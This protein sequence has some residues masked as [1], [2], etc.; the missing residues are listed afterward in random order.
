MYSRSTMVRRKSERKSVITGCFLNTD[1]VDKSNVSRYL[2][3]P[4]QGNNVS[5]SQAQNP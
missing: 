5:I 4:G 2:A 3:Q 1:E